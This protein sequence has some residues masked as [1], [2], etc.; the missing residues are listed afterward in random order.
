MRLKFALCLLLLVSACAKPSQQFSDTAVKVS[1]V[2]PPVTSATKSN[3]LPATNP[4]QPLSIPQLAYS[5]DYTLTVP[6][7]HVQS[8]L[9]R[10]QQA[11]AAAG[12]TVCQVVSSNLMSAGGGVVRAEL[13]LRATPAWLTR[14]RNGLDTDARIANGR[15]STANVESEDLSTAIVDTEAAVRAKT[16]LRDRIQQLLAQRPGK[17]SDVLEAETELAKVQGELDATQSELA[18]MRTRVTTSKLTISYEAEGVVGRTSITYPLQQALESFLGN[19]LLVFGLLLTLASYLLPLAIVI[20]SIGWFGWL[21]R[22]RSASKRKRPSS[23][24]E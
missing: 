9:D 10:H 23:T 8:L 24:E 4:D 2:K 6:S 20:G 12:P 18:V 19:V 1:Q 5:Y 3:G 14:F 17:L 16:T 11:C 7:T 21:L 22:R 15:V 13:A